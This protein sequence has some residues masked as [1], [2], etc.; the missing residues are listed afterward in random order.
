MGQ[1]ESEV[2]WRGESELVGHG[3]SEG[4]GEGD[5]YVLGVMIMLFGV[6]LGRHMR[7]KV[8]SSESVDE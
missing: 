2:D 4:P 3:L 1:R 5:V 8:S 6:H 7:V